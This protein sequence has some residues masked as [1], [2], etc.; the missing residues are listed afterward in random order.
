MASLWSPLIHLPSL[1]NHRNS[2]LNVVSEKI[3]EDLKLHARYAAAAYCPTERVM[4]WSCGD[5]CESGLN[6]TSYFVSPSSQVAGF[7][8]YNP[9][10]RKMVVS[11]RGSSNIQNWIHDVQF[12]PIDFEYPHQASDYPLG[13][14]VHGGFFR[15]YESLRAQV[16]DAIELLGSILADEFPEYELIVTGHSLGA[17]IAVFAAMDLSQNYSGD[18]AAESFAINPK[19]MFVHTYGGPRIGNSGFARPGL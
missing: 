9:D 3:V 16:R 19:K 14:K 1:W 5:R 11:F 15:A 6:V 17:A 13:I 7:M 10:K 18:K 2:H 12:L 8:G 4:S